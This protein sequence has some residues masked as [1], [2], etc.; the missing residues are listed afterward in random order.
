MAT[1]HTSP[2]ALD[3]P[4][5]SRSRVKRYGLAGAGVVCVG[6]GGVGAVLPGLPTTVFLLMATW[7]F[8]RSCPWLTDRLVR[9]KFF[10]PFACYLVPGVVMPRRAKAISMAMMW[11]AI[12]L[13]TWVLL[14]SPAPA[15]VPGV[16]VASGLVGTWFIARQGRR[17]RLA[18]QEASDHDR[19][20]R[21]PEGRASR[22]HKNPACT[23]PTGASSKRP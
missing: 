23:T 5:I 13:S 19:V 21:H 8:A 17:V 7:C 10:S 18:A 3:V 14:R 22:A 20:R 1:L 15:W 2:T 4:R 9:N 6:L 16:V 11:T 12:A